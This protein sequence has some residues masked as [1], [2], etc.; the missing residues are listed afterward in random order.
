LGITKTR[1]EIKKKAVKK[2][3]GRH[4]TGLLYTIT[5]ELYLLCMAITAVIFVV[6][7]RAVPPWTAHSEW[8]S[9]SRAAA[10][11]AIYL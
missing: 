6:L 2:K 7:Y 8:R 11:T 9:S 10:A 4:S 3:D 5:H 1:K